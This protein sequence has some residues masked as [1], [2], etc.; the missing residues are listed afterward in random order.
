MFNANRMAC[1]HGHIW[2]NEHSGGLTQGRL[3]FESVEGVPTD[4]Y[5]PWAG[6]RDNRGEN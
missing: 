4:G 3:C 1:L 5:G 2:H 6:W